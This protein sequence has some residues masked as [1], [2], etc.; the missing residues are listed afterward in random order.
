MTVLVMSRR[1]RLRAATIAEIKEIARRHLLEGGQNAVSLRAV[2]RDMGMTAPALYRYFPS[3]ASLLSALTAD[4]YDEVR[5]ELEA[6]RD[7]EPDAGPLDR[8]EAVSKAFRAWA[9]GHP[10]EFSLVFGSPVPAFDAPHGATDAG[11]DADAD[12]HADAHAD[13]SDDESDDTDARAAKDMVHHRACGEAGARFGA[14][15]AGLFIEQWSITPFPT[16]DPIGLDPGLRAQLAELEGH[17]GSGMPIEAVYVYVSCWTRLYGTVSMEVFGHLRWALADAA[18]MF[19]TELA[20]LIAR[21]R[22]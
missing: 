21:L 22:P 14:V 15:F 13:E 4:I 19:E 6:A 7:R 17:L 8:L 9:I 16:P 18:P 3:V 11:T 5:L 2:A 20:D 10:V 12:V 1:D